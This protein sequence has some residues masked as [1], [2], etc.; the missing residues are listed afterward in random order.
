MPRRNGRLRA[1]SKSAMV[2]SGNS[3]V[4]GI[5]VAA[6]SDGTA[7]RVVRLGGHVSDWR[8]FRFGGPV[9]HSARRIHVFIHD[10]R[11]GPRVTI[12]LSQN[13]T[14]R[15]APTASRCRKTVQ[16]AVTCV[17]YGEAAMLTASGIP[18]RP[19][20][21]KGVGMYEHLRP[22]MSV[23]ALNPRTRCGAIGLALQQ[24]SASC[25]PGEQ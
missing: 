13:G 8:S 12:H 1:M 6:E 18:L 20:T 16:L 10:A 11:V 22:D 7:P 9:P 25:N 4:A 17:T 19:L 15:S 3:A 24:G 14:T 23:A 2:M 21:P 5:L